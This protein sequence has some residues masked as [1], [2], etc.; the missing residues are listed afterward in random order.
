[1]CV[2]ILNCAN[3][4]EIVASYCPSTVQTNQAELFVESYFFR[5]IGKTLVPAT[6]DFPVMRTTNQNDEQLKTPVTLIA[7]HSD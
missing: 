7:Y 2:R 3:L 4:C 1:M 5:I 6:R